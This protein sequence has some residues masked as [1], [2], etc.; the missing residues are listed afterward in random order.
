MKKE[1]RG[2]VRGRPTDGLDCTE[3]EEKRVQLHRQ[4]S[5]AD[6]Q[7]GKEEGEMRSKTRVRTLPGYQRDR[8][9]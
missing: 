4:R 6:R 2:R 5:T 3:K 9:V 8:A 1:G 7:R